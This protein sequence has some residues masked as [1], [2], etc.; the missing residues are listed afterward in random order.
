MRDIFV[1]KQ[2]FEKEVEIFAMLDK[3]MLITEGLNRRFPDGNHPFQ[4]ATRLL[5]ECGE[6]A[7]EINHF[8]GQGVKRD[9][10]GEPDKARL[11]KEVQDVIR[12]A[13]QVALHYQIE[14]ELNASI[15]QSYQ[16]MVDEGLI[17]NLVSNN[18]NG[19]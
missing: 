17:E 18:E 12:A 5:E 8:E 3:L 11:A 6:L 13:L 16:R 1:P 4:I 19:S 10:Y 9:K 15:Q 2:G 14:N 7:K